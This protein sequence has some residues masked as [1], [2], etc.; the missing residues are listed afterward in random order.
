M[1]G[2]EN[3]DAVTAIDTST[4]R[5]VATIPNGQAAQALVYVPQAVPTETAGTENLQ[6]LGTRRQRD[7]SRAGRSGRQKRR[8][9]CR[10]STKG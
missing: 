10:S 7:A 8:Q 4:N 5:I 1:S 9:P 6:P 3:G 2:L